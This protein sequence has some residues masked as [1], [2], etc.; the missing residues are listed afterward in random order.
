MIILITIIITSM[1]VVR[2]IIQVTLSFRETLIGTPPFFFFNSNILKLERF[3]LTQAIEHHLSRYSVLKANCDKSLISD[4]K[5]LQ[6]QKEGKKSVSSPKI[7]GR[8]NTYRISQGG[9]P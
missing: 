6:A 1:S 5:T 3:P 7:E 9:R 4:R 2:N 8:K